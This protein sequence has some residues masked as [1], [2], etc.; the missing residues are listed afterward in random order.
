MFNTHHA[1]FEVFMS[2]R[3]VINWAKIADFDRPPLQTSN[4]AGSNWESWGGRGSDVMQS[5]QQKQRG[6]LTHHLN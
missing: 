4:M 5:R 3:S 1:K 2:T 6:Y